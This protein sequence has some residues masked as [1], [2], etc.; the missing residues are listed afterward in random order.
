MDESLLTLTKHAGI[1]KLKTGV[2]TDGRL[3]ARKSE[4]QLD[5]GAYSDASALTVVKTGYRIT[6]PYRWGR[7]GD[8]R[9]RGAHQ[10]GAGRLVSRFWRDPGSFCVGI[11]DRHD[12]A[13]PRD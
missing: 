7:S 5:G 3:T 1:L 13:A 8:A 9:L 4:I 12:C 2:T 11:T 10:H 6:G